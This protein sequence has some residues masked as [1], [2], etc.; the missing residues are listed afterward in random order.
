MILLRFVLT[1]YIISY[2]IA[3][4]WDKHLYEWLMKTAERRA[5]EHKPYMRFKVPGYGKR[6]W[7]MTTNEKEYT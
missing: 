2:N 4:Q 1:L 3:C 7:L 6:L 5:V